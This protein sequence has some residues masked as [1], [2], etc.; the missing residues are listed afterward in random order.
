MKKNM[1]RNFLFI[2]LLALCPFLETACQ[3]PPPPSITE[4]KEMPPTVLW[5]TGLP[6]SGKTTLAKQLHKHVPLSVVIDEDLKTIQVAEMTQVILDS[7]PLV[8]ISDST[9]KQKE[10]EEART[11]IE[12]TGVR[13]VEVY[14][15]APL[16]LCIERDVKGQYK[17]ALKG[18]I[19]DFIGIGTPY[20]IP[21][22]PDVICQT[23]Q[24]DV[25]E[26]I[27]RILSAI[28][29]EIF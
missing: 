9:P 3:K 2:V 4:K 24:E 7:V 11:L 18:E 28:N 22:K 13:F 23:D 14:I 6:C 1:K 8:I 16:E 26:S 20:Q 5:L 12:K 15:D 19:S 10:R 27:S 29:E 17:K 21:N 25:Q